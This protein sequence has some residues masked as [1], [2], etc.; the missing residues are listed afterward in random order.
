MGWWHLL[1]PANHGWGL[2]GSATAGT[3]TA[4][5]VSLNRDVP[6]SR[7]TRPRIPG[8]KHRDRVDDGASTS[9]SL[10]LP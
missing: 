2:G 1:V 3:R 10:L 4:A 8:L 6:S 9:L 7:T 5:S